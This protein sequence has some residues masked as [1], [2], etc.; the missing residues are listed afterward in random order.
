LRRVAPGGWESASSDEIQLRDKL[1]AGL[2]ESADAITVRSALNSLFRSF[3]TKFVPRFL[4]FINKRY[5]SLR[6]EMAL[7]QHLGLLFYS[8]LPYARSEKDNRCP[9]AQIVSVQSD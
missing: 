8:M 7:S 4:R 3:K 1:V 2:S 5:P 6:S 9:E